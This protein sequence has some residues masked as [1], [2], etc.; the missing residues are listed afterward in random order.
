MDLTAELTDMAR[1]AGASLAGVASVDRFDGAP[2]G[3]HPRELLPGA[4][5][6][7]TFGIRILDRVLEWLD[8]L[9]G[10]P[11]FPE[12]MRLEALHALFYRR[13][14]YDI[15]ND[16]LNHVALTLANHLEDLG[17]ASLFF[18]A[19]YGAMPETM[20]QVPGMFSQRHAAVRA[21]LGEFGFNNVVVTP[22]YGPRIRFNSVITTAPLAPSPLLQ[23]KTCLGADC[24]IC[25]DECPAGAFTLQPQA[26]FKGIWL[27]PVSRTDWSVCRKSQATSACMG[28]CLR[29]CPTG[30]SVAD[31]TQETPPPCMR[32]L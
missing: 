9:Q 13:S 21:G 4:E 2:R 7:F 25:V 31:H 24:N 22:R 5:S 15:I 6:V 10:S 30:R 16:R 28:H 1:T 26:N 14:G 23:A 20:T 27:D 19:T 32:K 18:P 29:V 3:H 8:L 11:F 12:D 17:Y